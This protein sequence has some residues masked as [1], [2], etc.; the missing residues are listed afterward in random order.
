MPPRKMEGAL[1]IILIIVF[2]GVFA[3]ALSVRYP[4]GSSAE[5]NFAGPDWT[6]IDAVCPPA[7]PD[8]EKAIK[9]II[10]G[11]VLGE[12]RVKSQYVQ[13]ADQC[14]ELCKKGCSGWAF[15]KSE[16]HPSLA[17]LYEC[18]TFTVDDENLIL[19][20]PAA[21]GDYFSQ[22]VACAPRG[23]TASPDIPAGELAAVGA[24]PHE[25]KQATSPRACMGMCEESPECIGATFHGHNGECNLYSSPRGLTLK[26][27]PGTRHATSTTFYVGAHA[28]PFEGAR[29]QE[30]SS[31]P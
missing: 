22:S 15:A 23:G 20:P 28:L 24:K 6:K 19:Y 4:K 1:L 29:L 27:Y 25:T 10:A 2:I 8:P 9:V 12:P 16:P 26:T 11:R 17:K 30:V 3:A 5:D 14:A 21:K 13:N 18:R 31:R 7:N